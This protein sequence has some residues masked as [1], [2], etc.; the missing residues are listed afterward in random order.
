MA[1]VQEQAL[2]PS[3]GYRSPPPHLHWAKIPQYLSHT[4]KTTL[5]CSSANYFL[6]LV[7]PAIVAAEFKWNPVAVFLLNFLAILPLAELL[8]WSTEQLAGSVGQTLGGLL[9]ATMGNAVEMIVGITALRQE[10]F[11]IVQSSMIGSILSSILLI[12]GSCFFTA[13]YKEKVVNFNVDLIGVMSSLMIVS[14]AS[15]IIPSASYFADLSAQGMES[16]NDYILTLS[17]I[18]AI[19][20]FSFY[21]VYLVFQLRTHADIFADPEAE[22]PES[23]ALDPWAA[24]L[25]LLAATVGVSVC[26]DCLVD[27]VDGFVEKLGVSRAF[28]GLIIVPIVGNAGEFVATIHQARKNNMNFAIKL[29]VES[30]LQIALFVTP[31]LVIVGWII[32]KNMS[33][34]FDTFQTTVLSMAVIVVS[35]LIRD[36]RSNYFE[37]FLLVST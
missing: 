15:L 3:N 1:S 4:I 10:Q 8:S 33:L 16:S 36:G 21:V 22:E 11:S 17:H 5:L 24:S 13:G 30:T 9:N 29:I 6:A 25:I 34:R 28:I 32:G 20:L 19:I 35:C 31:F 2:G 23:P 37:G 12:L 14:A 7:P 27:S 26:S 18:A